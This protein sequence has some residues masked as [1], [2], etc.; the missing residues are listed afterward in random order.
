MRELPALADV[1][2]TVLEIMPLA[3]FPGR[4]G[5]GYDGVNL[6][7]PAHIYGRPED[8]AAFVDRAHSL[9]LA[10]ILDVVYNHL[11]PDGNY[12]GQFS[13]DYFSSKYETEWGEAINFDG[14]NSGPVREYFAENAAYWIREFHLDGLRLDAT[15]SIFDDSREHILTVIGKRVREAAAGR[16]A[17]VVAENEPQQT[18]LVRSVERGGYGLD[19]LWNDDLHHTAMVALTGHNDSYYTDY[20]GTPQE[21]ISA[22]KYGYLYQGQR[23]KWQEKRR[24]T[25]GY[26]LPPAAFITFVQNHDQIANSARGDRVHRLTSAGR[27]R[28]MTALILLAP[29]TPM[30]FQGQEFA[31]SAP[32]LYFADHEP[33]LAELVAKGRIE[34]LEQ[35]RSLRQPEMQ[36]C[37]ARPDEASTFERCKLDHSEREKHRE[38][39]L[40][41]RDLLRLR[42]EDPVLRAQERRAVDGAVL[43]TNAFVLRYFNADHGDR[44]LLVNFGNDVHL[45][46]APE[47]L[48]APPEGMEWEKVFSTEDP[49]YGGCGTAA[50]DTEEN[51]WIPGEAAV[52]MRPIPAPPSV[53]QSKPD[54]KQHEH[55]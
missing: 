52:F 25:P 36:A 1:G 38:I 3:E 26:D 18:K 17:I 4:F 16:N 2:V 47:P 37:F 27:L 50:L 55:A 41:H 11:G 35:W 24:G 46:P 48:L 31:A 9:G 14:E 45:D 19:G 53:K 54:K 22:I 44:L 12:L 5:W 23:Y 43:S 13:R 6:F 15:Q 39:W 51:W 21:F 33:R 32:F 49:P 20:L 30:L 10:V 42:R 8:F 34:F 7:A 40:L 28:A 29:G